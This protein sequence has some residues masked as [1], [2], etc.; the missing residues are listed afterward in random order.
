MDSNE[1]FEKYPTNKLR[2]NY[3]KMMKEKASSEH[4]V[5]NLDS[6]EQRSKEVDFFSS[7]FSNNKND[8]I[9]SLD[10]HQ[11]SQINTSQVTKR[12]RTPEYSSSDNFDDLI[13]NNS[14]SKQSRT[15]DNSRT[16]RIDD[17]FDNEPSQFLFSGNHTLNQSNKSEPNKVNK[18]EPEFDDNDINLPSRTIRK[19]EDVALS[20]VDNKHLA[21]Y[22]K[23]NM[24]YDNKARYA[25]NDMMRLN[26]GNEFIVPSRGERKKYDKSIDVSEIIS[27]IEKLE[28]KDV[29]YIKQLND[30]NNMNTSNNRNNSNYDNGV[31]QQSQNLKKNEE[32]TK[33]KQ[34]IKITKSVVKK[35]SLWILA[36]TAWLLVA[37]PMII[38]ASKVLSS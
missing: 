28:N 32:P 38:I 21:D 12:T 36:I 30:V 17:S 6:F 27:N 10:N 26:V 33:K 37:I 35:V 4:T 18:S 8:F 2:T 15:I 24:C 14:A 31:Y 23:N 34:K 22:Q 9:A 5:N 7:S 29:D 16:K 3:V 25:D 11:E 20:N 19:L 1:I 13:S